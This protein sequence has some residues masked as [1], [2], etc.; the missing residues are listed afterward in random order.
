MGLIKPSK[1]IHSA[2]LH[3]VVVLVCTSL[4][5]GQANAKSLEG[6]TSHGTTKDCEQNSLERLDFNLEKLLAILKGEPAPLAISVDVA[7]DTFIAKAKDLSI[8]G[9]YQKKSGKVI[10]VAV[11]GLG[12][13]FESTV[14][15]VIDLAN[16][17]NSADGKM[18]KEKMINAIRTQQN[19]E[20]FLD[21]A[22]TRYHLQKF[23]GRLN[24]HCTN[25][26]AD[27][28]AIVKAQPAI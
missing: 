21:Q 9:C 27:D 13:Q 12:K 8:S 2:V 4:H 16:L 17:K 22:G 3:F 11:N 10:G 5:C 20:V 19:P 6:P 23:S 1:P 25:A 26:R 14:L 28:R 7:P 15:K 18:L 24:F